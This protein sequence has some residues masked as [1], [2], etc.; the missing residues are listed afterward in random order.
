MHVT[1]IFLLY[2]GSKITQSTDVY[3]GHR[4][5]QRWQ[6]NGGALNQVMVANNNTWL[7]FYL[8]TMLW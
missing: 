6:L 8:Y 3:V 2:L 7:C 1:F 4:W 5:W